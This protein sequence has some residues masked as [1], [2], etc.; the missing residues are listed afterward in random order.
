[1]AIQDLEGQGS[2]DS[3]TILRWNV[4]GNV[5]KQTT[6]CTQ[7]HFL[8][9][10]FHGLHGEKEKTS[11]FNRRGRPTEFLISSQALLVRRHQLSSPNFRLMCAQSAQVD[12]SL[13]PVHVDGV[14]ILV[15]VKPC[16]GKSWQQQ[17]RFEPNGPAHPIFKGFI[18]QHENNV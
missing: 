12:T 18:F 1:M 15:P 3:L 17:G 9:S 11:C 16:H 14:R 10:S 5:G 7:L 6:F 8:S 4:A 2:A 13:Q